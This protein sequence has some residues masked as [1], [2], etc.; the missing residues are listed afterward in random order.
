[1]AEDKNDNPLESISSLTSIGFDLDSD[2]SQQTTSNEQMKISRKRQQSFVPPE[3]F[4]S[5]FTVFE[6][7]L[8]N[9]FFNVPNDTISLLLICSQH[10]KIALQ[11]LLNFYFFPSLIQFPD[12]SLNEQI[13]SF[14]FN[15]L[16]PNGKFKS[17]FLLILID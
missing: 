7:D 13:T 3:K 10:N 12:Q 17:I 5:L 6:N 1:M 2:Q 14:V 9:C 4:G 16:F 8:D 11:Q 15:S